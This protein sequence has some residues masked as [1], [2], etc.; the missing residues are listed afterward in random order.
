MN[1]GFIIRTIVCLALIA[2]W[3]RVLIG[4]P[5]HCVL[6]NPELLWIGAQEALNRAHSACQV[7]TLPAP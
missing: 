5:L 1:V 4:I 2:I 6:S 7:V 3:H